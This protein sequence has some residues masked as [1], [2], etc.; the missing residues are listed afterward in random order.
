MGK[1]DYQKEHTDTL[2]DEHVVGRMKSHGET[3]EILIEPDEVEK[4]RSGQDIDLLESMPVE[5]VFIDANKG[6]EAPKHMM[7]KAFETTDIEEIATTILKKGEV[8]L[9]TEQRNK[10]QEQKRK[11]IVSRI[12]K[13]SYN[14]QTDT[15]HPP[16]RIENAM[17][18]ADV[19]IDPFKPVSLQMDEVVE[20]IRELIPLSFEKKRVRVTVRGDLQ[21]KIYGPLKRIGNIEEEEWLEDGSWQAMVKLPAGKQEE[22]FEKMNEITKGK[23]E[24][25]E[26]DRNR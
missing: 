21:G 16:Q 22:L 7:E 20:N 2:L 14:P 5:K 19:H 10:R 24:M 23:A 26:I 17:S 15:P 18:E 12:A 8:Q 9:T 6:K 4:F 13:N 25:A 11:E 3:F 1:K